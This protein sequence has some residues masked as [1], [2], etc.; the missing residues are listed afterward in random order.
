MDLLSLFSILLI[1]LLCVLVLMPMIGFIVAFFVSYTA[2]GCEKLKPA[3]SPKGKALIVYEPGA[4]PLTKKAA[5]NLGK[6][7]QGRGYEADVAGIRSAAARDSAGYDVLLVGTPTYLGKP[8]P[9]VI[10]YLKSLSPA[11]GRIVGLFP[12][13][14]RGLTPE[15][16]MPKRIV[17]ALVDPLQQR[18]IDV[19]A[20]TFI[21]VGEFDYEQYVAQLLG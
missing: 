13:G 6:V 9:H 18:S 3:G 4:S 15:G 8:T 11:N 16:A 2:T 20:I 21:G 5:D 1:I 19:K 14:I 7:L 17:D 12:T 10:K